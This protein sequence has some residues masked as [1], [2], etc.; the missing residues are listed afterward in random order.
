M[1]IL[2]CLIGGQQ[3]PNLF[4]VLRCSPERIILVHT[5]DSRDEADRLRSFLKSR[6]VEQIQLFKVDPYHPRLIHQAAEQL[7]QQL[8]SREIILNYTGGTKPIAIGFYEVFRSNQLVYVD[9]QTETF[10]WGEADRLKEEPIDLKPDLPELLH[11]EGADIRSVE[12]HNRLLEFKDLTEYLYRVRRDNLEANEKLKLFNQHAVAARVENDPHSW[13]PDYDDGRLRVQEIDPQ[14]IEVSFDGHRFEM[15]KKDSWLTY[16]TGGWF[17][18]WVYHRLY[19]T[20]EYDDVRCNITFRSENTSRDGLNTKNEID[21][22]AIR[23]G[24]PVFVECKTGGVQQSH[25]T[26]LYAVK[27]H[28][29]STYTLP[30]MVML[31]PRVDRVLQEKMRDYGIR[32]IRGGDNLETEFD[33]LHDEIVIGK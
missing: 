20:G 1:S 17:E 4:S 24:I 22:A 13:K 31:Q 29:G 11:L 15:K 32:L 14:K 25:I 3:A 18:Q 26:N 21:V 12:D 23:N 9:T 8:G 10:W 30:V 28:Y 27:Q 16:F 19:D 33:Q 2:I 7:K 6:Q 5:E